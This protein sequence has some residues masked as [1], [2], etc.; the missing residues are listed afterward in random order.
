MNLKKATVM[1]PNL[2]TVGN[3]VLGFF[4]ITAA[5]DNR[6]VAAPTAIFIAHIM[7]ILDGRIARWMG[8]TSHFGAEFD[9]FADWISFGIAPA[10]MVYLLALKD[11]GKPGFL[12]AFFFVF[13]AAWRLA[14]FN[15][16]SAEGDG[17][18]SLSFTG[19]PMPAAG[20]FIS[21]LVLLFGLYQNDHQGRTMRL[22]YDQ[23]PL[24]RQGI[25]VIMFIVGFL[26]MSNVQ[27]AAFK[28]THIFRPRSLRALLMTLFV[29]FM[30]YWYPQNTIFI[31]YT[32]YILWGIIN[33]GYRTYR[34]RKNIPEKIA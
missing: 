14:R 17:T 18:P 28:K 2:F 13:A 27:Y 9:S 8:V 3:M 19:L 23:V 22:I 7:D 24:L 5:L 20:G 6:W 16:K 30:I 4:A 26:M 29:F 32:S 31:L 33:T 10:F 21:V 11:H 34:M 12:L 25:P 1:V 15:V